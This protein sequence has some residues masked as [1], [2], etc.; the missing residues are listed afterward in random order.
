[1]RRVPVLIATILLTGASA[2]ACG[3]SDDPAPSG[4]SPS[5]GASSSEESDDTSSELLDACGAVSADEVGAI[6]D[7]TF[8]SEVGPF[9]ACEFD[10]EDP[11][12]TSLSV[13]AQLL[14]ELGGGFEVYQSGSKLAF[15]DGKQVDVPGVGDAAFITTG[16]FGEGTNIQLQAATLIDG[17]VITVSLTQASDIAED[18]LV[19]QAN[20]LLTLVASKV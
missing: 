11:R 1:M 16:T 10:Q 20:E 17:Q 18:V 6:L 19:G 14:S 7:G 13:D 2:S 15:T 9:D 4:D 12:A 5:T 3:G 8:T